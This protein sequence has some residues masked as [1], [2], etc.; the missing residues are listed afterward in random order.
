MASD[1]ESTSLTYAVVDQPSHGS[2][3]LSQDGTFSY[4]PNGDY[5]GTD[6]FTYKV[7]DGSRDSDVAT[8]DLT[9][10]PVND[11]PTAQNGSASGD[12]DTT[13]TGTV[14]VEDLDGDPLSTSW[15][16]NPAMA[17]SR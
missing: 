6:S 9:V 4:T 11:A 3:T 16:R 2:V 12:E 15:S 14:T 1:V 13:I 17:A 7:N 5:S 10:N 8:V